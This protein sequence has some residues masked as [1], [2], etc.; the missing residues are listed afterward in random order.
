[1]WSLGKRIGMLFRRGRRS[2]E[3]GKGRSG[4]WTCYCYLVVGYEA[5]DLKCA[6]RWWMPG[7]LCWTYRWRQVV[8]V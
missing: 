3:Y 5:A 4:M 6:D 7:R 8:R 1:M 2:C